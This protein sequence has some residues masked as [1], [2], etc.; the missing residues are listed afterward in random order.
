MTPGL[1]WPWRA[2]KGGRVLAE[3]GECVT[4]CPDRR[5]AK[6]L[7]REVEPLLREL[8]GPTAPVTSY[9]LPETWTIN[10][11]GV[12][13]TYTATAQGFADA[14]N[15]SASAAFATASAATSGTVT[16]TFRDDAA[17]IGGFAALEQLGLDIASRS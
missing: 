7:I 13:H 17:T 6:A 16:L 1:P 8:V 15:A 14:F 11:N 9:L 5:Q 10:V 4:R 12:E 3:N 2:F